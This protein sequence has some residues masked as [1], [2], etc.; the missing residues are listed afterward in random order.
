MSRF[1]MLV[2]RLA[3][4]EEAA[5]NVLVKAKA[6]IHSRGDDEDISPEERDLVEALVDLSELVDW[7]KDGD[8]F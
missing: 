7:G 8:W 2:D 1:E 4:L 5:T 6:F 3:D